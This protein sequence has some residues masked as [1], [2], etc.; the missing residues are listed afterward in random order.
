[1]RKSIL[2]VMGAALFALVAIPNS[3][4]VTLW[5]FDFSGYINQVSYSGNFPSDAT[6]PFASGDRFSGTFTY[7]L[8]V[9]DLWIQLGGKDQY[10]QSAYYPMDPRDPYYGMQVQINH[11]DFK[12]NPANAVL[13]WDNEFYNLGGADRLDFI[14]SMVRNP[15]FWGVTPQFPF[16][17]QEG[18]IGWTLQ[19]NAMTAI[20]NQSLPT[21]IQLIDWPINEFQIT[22]AYYDFSISED[23]LYALAIEGTVDWIAPVSHPGPAP[24]PEPAALLLTGA[25]LLSMTG[26]IRKIGK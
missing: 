14:Y 17:M 24:V 1:M 19:D 7:D 9:V 4:A 21:A 2:I 16:G 26:L 6:G 5:R 13:V 12:T 11:Y 25:G 10:P 22:G 18:K 3:F 15:D 23:R 20:H 8:D